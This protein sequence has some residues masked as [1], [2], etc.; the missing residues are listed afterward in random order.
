MT[1]RLL[2]RRPLATALAPWVGAGVLTP[3]DAQLAATLCTLAGEADV[4]VGLGVAL[5]I[6]APRSGHVALDPFRIEEQVLADVEH[7]DPDAVEAVIELDW[8]P[9]A[10]AWCERIAASPVT[11]A[12]GAPVVVDHGLVYLR[13]FHQQECR[14]ADRLRV[15]AADVGSGAGGR[16]DLDLVAGTLQLDGWQRTAV[17][18]C[19]GGRLGVLTGG[20]GTGKTR[21]VAALLSVLFRTHGPDLRVALAAPT[22]KAAGR[23]GESIAASVELLRRSTAD[24]FDTVADRMTTL[25]TSTVH[26]LLGARPD[27][28]G[29]RH[30]ARRPLPHDVV[31]IDEASML[32]LSMTDALLDALRPGSRLVL[33]GDPG[34]L[35]SVE[36]GSVLG[37][38]A[39]ATGTLADRVAELTLSRRFPPDSRIGRFAAAVREGDVGTAD[40]VLSETPGD[41]DTTGAAV[42]VHVDAPA[43]VRDGLAA[44]ARA[45]VDAA[46]RGDAD[47]AVDLLHHQRILCAHRRGWAGVSHWNRVIEG[48]LAAEG[49]PT[50]GMYTGRPLMVTVNDPTRGLFNGDLGVVVRTPEGARVAFGPGDP[51]RLVAPSHLDAIETVHAMTIHK[52]QG[53]EFDHVVVVLPSADSRLATRELLYTA[54]TRARSSVTLVG[55][56]ATVAAAIGRSNPR[57]SALRQRLSA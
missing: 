43:A 25:E 47:G 22:G 6:R 50:R 37:D 26:R 2:D 56:R 34:Q 27:G 44:H 7:L 57:T 4:A 10:A 38:I 20:P 21:T 9:N 52:S 42:L 17:E 30:D 49:A 11:A 32:S 46:R 23:M 39:T 53:S 19:L 54:V 13:R 16:A 48:Y 40:A 31:I 35:A 8:P 33:V 36:A 28:A 29:F 5:A 1:A 14:V 15:M 12:A 18:R 51:P 24:G 3:G 55:D 41:P 45:L